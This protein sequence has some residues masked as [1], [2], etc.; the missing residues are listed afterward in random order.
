MPK[1]SVAYPK[2][3]DLI[4][5]A[6]AKNKNVA[7][8]PNSERAIWAEFMPSPP[9]GL[10]RKKASVIYF[11]G[12]MSSF[13][14]QIQDIPAAFV[15]VMEKAKVDF[16]ILGEKEWCCGYPLI[17]AGMQREAEELIEHNIRAIEKTGA[18]KVVFSCPSCY[19]TFREHYSLGAELYHH[20]EFIQELIDEGKLRLRGYEAKLTYHDP[21]DLG[22]HS[23]IYEAPRRVLRALNTELVEMAR[24]REIALCCGGGGDLELVEPELTTNI[25]CSVANE[26]RETGAGVLVTAC[27]QCKR[28]LKK[29]VVEAGAKLEVKDIAEVVL[30]AVE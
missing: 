9:K 25:S 30:E 21:C 23:Q 15:Q 20:T 24:T 12:C 26:A 14:P 3:L 10:F 19:R 4:R 17:V 18:D 13:S 7:N 28:V 16:A 5:E 6:I 2:S 22:R 8:F 11:V 29:G 27:Q 1:L